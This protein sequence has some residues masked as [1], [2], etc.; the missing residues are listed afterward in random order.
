[1]DV[2]I[3]KLEKEPQIAILRIDERYFEQISR[4]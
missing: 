3:I 2:D 1:M 4:D